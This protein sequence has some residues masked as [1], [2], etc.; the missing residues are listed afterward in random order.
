MNSR[1]TY[2]MFIMDYNGNKCCRGQWISIGAIPPYP[3][4]KPHN[5]TGGKIQQ[6]THQHED[7]YR[8]Y[9][10]CVEESIQVRKPFVY[11]V[12]V[13]TILYAPMV[14]TWQ[15]TTCFTLYVN[16][17]HR[18]LHRSGGEL[19]YS[20]VKCG[21]IIAACILLHNRCIKRGIPVPADV[22]IHGWSW[23]IYTSWLHNILTSISR[24]RV[25]IY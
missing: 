18:C 22:C 8:A 9:L 14:M 24:Y 2:S 20:P 11:T 1:V 19:Q 15:Y 25:L 4:E 6:G 3:S 12:T 13:G 7:Y 5:T 16:A 17:F 23:K 21:N 10:W